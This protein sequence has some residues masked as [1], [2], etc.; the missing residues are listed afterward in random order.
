MKLK[1]ERGITLIALIVTIIVLMILAGVSINLLFGQYGIITRAIEARD[2]TKIGEYKEKIDLIRLDLQMM[3]PDYEAPTKA[4]MKTEFD[5]NQKTWVATTRFII[6]KGMEKLELTTKEGYIF[7]ITETTT[8]YKGK[9]EVVD[10]SALESADVI[11][12]KLTEQLTNTNKV[13]ITDLSGKDY[14]EIKYQIGSTEGEWQDINSGDIVDVAY[15]T[16]IYAKLVYGSDSGVIHKLVISNTSPTIVAKTV[17]TT[18]MVRKTNKSLADL[19]EITWGSDGTGTVEYKVTGNLTFNNTS[20][21]NTNISNI[22]DLE[23]GT[24]NVLCTITSPSNEVV[25]ATN[26]NVKITTLSNTTV[27]DACNTQ[28]DAKAIY[29]SYD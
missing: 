4:Q 7:Y 15:G 5:E 10:T 28:V 27:A 8:E 9:G 17:D 14:Y 18:N 21:S 11:E 6:D 26:E 1:K 23:L 29:S 3:D 19:F 24:Y 25:S 13:Q 22:S 12:I 2:A 16:T 20:F